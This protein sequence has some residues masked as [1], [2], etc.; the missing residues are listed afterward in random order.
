MHTL[1][2][3][4]EQDNSFHEARLRDRGHYDPSL[5]YV[6]CTMAV[7]GDVSS[8]TSFEFLIN[9]VNSPKYNGKNPHQF[10]QCPI[11]QIILDSTPQY[12]ANMGGVVT[13]VKSTPPHFA[14]YYV[15]PKYVRATW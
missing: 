8:C 12:R 9:S 5:E 1:S 4:M 7:W 3:F 6:V 15:L 14:L 2:N 11:D 13:R 10:N